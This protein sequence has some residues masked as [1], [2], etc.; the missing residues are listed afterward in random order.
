MEIVAQYGYILAALVILG[1]MYYLT[2]W[3]GEGLY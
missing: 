1:G 3:E 2:R